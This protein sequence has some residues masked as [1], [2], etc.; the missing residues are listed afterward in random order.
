MQ[1]SMAE[2]L[3]R[4]VKR[5]HEQ[6]QIRSEPDGEL[7]RRFAADR[8]EPAFEELL[9]RHGPLVWGVCVRTLG[10]TPE[11]EDAFQAVFLVLVR[12][13]THI[14]HQAQIAGWLH[15]TAQKVVRRARQQQVRR[16]SREQ[17]CEAAPEPCHTP[18]SPRDW[19]P[20]FDCALQ[21]LPEKYREVLILCE[22]QERTRSEAARILS[23]NENTLSSRLARAKEMLRAKL[24]PTGVSLPTGLALVV[25]AAL[26]SA[27]LQ[28]SL[29]VISHAGSLSRVIPA[30]LL[31]LVHG[32]SKLMLISKSLTCL[33][34]G[35]LV[36]LGL[37]HSEATPQSKSEPQLPVAQP[38]VPARNILPESGKSNAVTIPTPSASKENIKDLLLIQGKWH[39]KS[40]TRRKGTD[41]QTGKSGERSCLFKSE[42]QVTEVYFFGNEIWAT[43]DGT[44]G[45]IGTFTLGESYNPRRI[46]IQIPEMDV[47]E[48]NWNSY[49]V[50]SFN[51]NG[52]LVLLI[53]PKRINRPTFEKEKS[54]SATEEIEILLERQKDSD[55]NLSNDVT[56][57]L[58]GWTVT[59]ATQSGKPITQ[60]TSIEFGPTRALIEVKMAD[61]NGTKMRGFESMR[62]TLNSSRNPRWITLQ[63]ANR[64]EKEEFHARGIYSL[65]GDTLTIALTDSNGRPSEFESSE[66]SDNMVLTAKR[67]PLRNF[68]IEEVHY[69]VQ[70]PPTRE[71][72]LA[73]KDVSLQDVIEVN[74]SKI[75]IPFEMNE[76]LAKEVRAVI[77]WAS[78]DHGKSFEQI[79]SKS[80]PS[81]GIYEFAY[82]ARK[83]GEVHFA[84]QT[85]NQQGVAHPPHEMLKSQL[86][87]RFI[88]PSPTPREIPTL[89]LEVAPTVKGNLTPTLSPSQPNRLQEEN[90]ELRRKLDELMK[91]VELLEKSGGTKK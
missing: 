1:S 67:K 16:R 81:T 55:L 88:L 57:L 49:G 43:L 4:R 63:P 61:A 62:Y 89:R 20:L 22:L 73:I 78:H 51:P 41:E 33:A 38:S 30:S 19:R 74:D 32:G 79:E 82:E 70:L 77:L 36:T 45:L 31:P 76:R 75:M 85:I 50:Y 21:K 29:K 72:T 35:V 84:M 44:Q 17:S 26:Q 47:P 90:Q 9:R 71:N 2:S 59:H 7:L 6:D 28:V 91:R 80:N 58:G 12:K 5:I 64:P 69:S 68:Q 13:A 48:I 15:G 40:V 53:G 46:D 39:A 86:K 54:A 24:A 14:V 18:D 87:V 37:I 60:L 42:H 83:S 25:P 56:E 3:W 11:A 8:D 34:V 65:S 23:L 66:G 52:E 10:M 27:A